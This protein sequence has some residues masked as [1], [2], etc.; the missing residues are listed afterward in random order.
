MFPPKVPG[1]FSPG[2]YFFKELNSLGFHRGLKTCEHYRRLYNNNDLDFI[3]PPLPLTGEL[4]SS[5]FEGCDNKIRKEAK[6]CSL[7]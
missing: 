5:A 6:I 3:F 1:T 2:N 4:S 7:S